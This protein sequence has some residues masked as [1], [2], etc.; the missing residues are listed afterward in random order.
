[1][2]RIL[3]SHKV[4]ILPVP[5]VEISWKMNAQCHNKLKK[6]EGSSQKHGR[7]LIHKPNAFG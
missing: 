5:Q 7:N 6:E 1:M 2:H 4:P 3:V